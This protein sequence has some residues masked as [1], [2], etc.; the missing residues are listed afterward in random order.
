MDIYSPTIFHT[1][2]P[3]SDSH[4]KLPA[5]NFLKNHDLSSSNNIGQKLYRMKQNK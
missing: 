4:R 2:D 1:L 3:E 5:L